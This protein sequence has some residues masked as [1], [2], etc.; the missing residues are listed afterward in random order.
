MGWDK[1]QGKARHEWAEVHWQTCRNVLT[2]TCWDPAG[3]QHRWLSS[4]KPTARPQ[5]C[6]VP[7][8][9][10]RNGAELWHWMGSFQKQQITKEF[11]VGQDSVQ[12]ITDNLLQDFSYHQSSWSPELPW[13]RTELCPPRGSR[14]PSKQQWPFTAMPA[15][16]G[17]YTPCREQCCIHVLTALSTLL[18]GRAIHNEHFRGQHALWTSSQ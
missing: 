18:W 1:V 17:N 13:G 15:D 12:N 5:L 4:P 11:G 6:P 14:H 2:L 7:R 3:D 16:I 9:P 10:P 8:A